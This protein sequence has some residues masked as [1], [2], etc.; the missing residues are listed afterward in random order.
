MKDDELFYIY[1]GISIFYDK[2]ENRLWITP[3]DKTL[4]DRNERDYPNVY[5]I[6]NKGNDYLRRGFPLKCLN[7]YRKNE[8]MYFGTHDKEIENHNSSLVKN[9]YNHVTLDHKHIFIRN[10]NNV[11]EKHE[12]PEELSKQL[13]NFINEKQ[14]Q[15]EEN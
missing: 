14:S 13:E 2:S 1:R 4:V 5:F 6:L 11:F 9:K 7:L 3:E 8:M 10:R 15:E 12:L